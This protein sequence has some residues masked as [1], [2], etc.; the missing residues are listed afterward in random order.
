M[1]NS[2]DDLVSV[3]ATLFNWR[4]LRPVKSHDFK[5]LPQSPPHRRSKQALAHRFADTMAEIPSRLV[6]DA[7]HP[8][9]FMRAYTLLGRA[10]QM[11]GIDPR[12]NGQM[13]VP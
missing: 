4:L 7:Q 3:A 2:A 8:V 6:S 5:I 13:A 1:D 9:Q 12:V 10:P 11:K